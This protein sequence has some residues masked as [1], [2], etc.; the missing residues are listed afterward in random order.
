MEMLSS[1]E[2]KLS[3]EFSFLESFTNLERTPEKSRKE[4]KLERMRAMLEYFHNPQNSFRTIHIA[5]SKGKGSTSTIAASMLESHGYK[6]GLFTSPHLVSYTERITLAGK[7]FPDDVYCQ[8]IEALRT[9]VADREFTRDMGMPTTFELLTL[10]AFIIFR[11]ENCQ[12]AVI[13]TGMGGRLDATNLI[14][15]EICIITPIEL[16]HCDVLGDTVEK[17][18]GEK[19]GI[20]KHK[21]P[22]VIQPQKNEALAVLQEKAAQQE[23]QFLYLPDETKISDIKVSTEGTSFRAKFRWTG[24][25]KFMTNL[26]GTFQADNI[27]SAILALKQVLPDLDIIR[28]LDAIKNIPLSGRME[29]LKTI[30]PVIIDGSHTENSIRRLQESY[31]Q[32]FNTKGILIFGSV[33][34]KNYQAML[35]ILCDNF[36][37]IIITKPQECRESNPE[38]IMQYCRSHY[39]NKD[40]RLETDRIRAVEMALRLAFPEKLPIVVTGSFYLA[41]A[42]KQ[43]LMKG[44]IGEISDR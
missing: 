41:G 38:E 5:G 27:C 44:A 20:I 40:F 14:T 42:I 11:K 33:T 8:A 17:I 6:T 4:Y 9:A 13:E 31:N 36:Q 18:A 10:L 19:A 37:T 39:G 3:E 32:M 28:C 34:G 35:D 12:W 22:A 24:R 26:T 1:S 23:S 25:R 21:I 16:E 7:P 2:N 43:L 30:P 15:P 29:L